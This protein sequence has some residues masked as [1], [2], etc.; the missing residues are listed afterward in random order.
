[1]EDTGGL[2]LLM[3]VAAPVLLAAAIVYGMMRNR[4]RTQ[5]EKRR[6]EQAT[7]EL[8]DREARDGETD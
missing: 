8:Y 5:A 3:V 4:G 7:R 2:T 1:M 6:T